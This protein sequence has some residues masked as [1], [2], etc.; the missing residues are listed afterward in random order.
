[1]GDVEESIKLGILLTLVLCIFPVLIEYFNLHY[2]SLITF[3][4]LCRSLYFPV[5]FVLDLLYDS[6]ILPLR[7]L[8]NKASYVIL[9][10][11]ALIQW[12]II[13]LL[14]QKILWKRPKEREKVVGVL[15]VIRRPVLV[16]IFL[17]VL[18]VI[19]YHLWDMRA[20]THCM[21]DSDCV[22]GGDCCD[23]QKCV[24]K[25]W[26]ARFD[27]KYCKSPWCFS[28]ILPR[29]E[30]ECTNNKCT[31]KK[32]TSRSTSSTSITTT[33]SSTSTTTSTSLTTSSTATSSSSTT[34]L[35]KEVFSC[36]ED[37]DCTVV[38]EYCCGCNAGGRVMAISKDFIEVWQ[39]QNSYGGVC[40][41]PAVISQ[42][43]SCYSSPVCVNNTCILKPD[44]DRLCT[45]RDIMSNCG[46]AT[47]TPIPGESQQHGVSCGYI[48]FLCGDIDISTTCGSDDDCRTSCDKK[49]GRGNCYNKEY[50]YDYGKPDDVCC[51]CRDC[52]PCITCECIDNTCTPK[53]LENQSCC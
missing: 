39:E 7:H 53:P 16:L 35:P 27:K 13:V 42:H 31:I 19:S 32:I 48:N 52:R 10:I 51:Y 38:N 26:Q 24:N 15:K 43:I 37:S 45:Q 1:M 29:P 14:I 18:A 22:P 6:S 47:P 8:S 17:T 25:E 41:C 30:C 9:V 50:L 33:T 21:V 12:V 36:Q 34:L 46:W 40:G 11:L 49:I 4:R 5:F 28:W 23:D 20:K 2:T 3:R 44:L